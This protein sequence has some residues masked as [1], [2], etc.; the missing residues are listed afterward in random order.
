M[1]QLKQSEEEIIKLGKR[2][3]EELKL[4]YTVNTLAR[5]M[6]HYLAEL[7]QNVEKCKSEQ[8]KK[9]LQKECCDIILK[10][11]SQKE[12]LPMRQPLEDLKPII[13]LLK[14]FKKDDLSFLPNWLEY[15]HLPSNNEWATFVDLVKNN[16]EK[17]FLTVISTNLN[18]DLL[19]K[20]SDWFIEN[21]DFLSDEEKDFLQHFEM[22][23]WSNDSSGVYD[24][25]NYESK[26]ES[27]SV[28]EKYKLIFDEMEELIEQQK[29]EL[30]K[31]KNT[32]LIR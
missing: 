28:D 20:T 8:E 21:K 14:V 17:L 16:T 11:W 15:R 26:I 19:S 10:V 29:Q 23:T 31:L 3:I 18:K 32:I 30:K 9:K 5:W 27:L 25:N 1:A 22:I 6:V 2:L 12:N 7:I 4:E 13:E 24:F